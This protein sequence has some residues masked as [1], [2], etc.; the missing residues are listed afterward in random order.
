MIENLVVLLFSILVHDIVAGD[1]ARMNAHQMKRGLSDGHTF[2]SVRTRVRL[3]ARVHPAVTQGTCV[4][5]GKAR[6]SETSMRT[7]RMTQLARALVV[8]GR[9]RARISKRLT[10]VSVVVRLARA[11]VVATRG[12]YAGGAVPAR[13]TLTIVHA[14]LTS[15]ARVAGPALTREASLTVVEHVCACGAVLAAVR[16]VLAIVSHF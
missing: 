5:G 15:S 3:R 12:P 2:G 9:A 4:G 7:S 16:M 13:H 1:Q 8:A 6:A 11:R 14:C 10:R